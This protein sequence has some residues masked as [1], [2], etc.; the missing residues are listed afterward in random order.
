[1]PIGC[2]RRCGFSMISRIINRNTFDVDFDSIESRK[3][4]DMRPTLFVSVRETLAS[5]ADSFEDRKRVKTVR[6]VSVV[7]STV[8]V[9]LI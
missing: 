1:M 7:L 2:D 5:K 8:T 4:E 9:M 3:Q 6:L